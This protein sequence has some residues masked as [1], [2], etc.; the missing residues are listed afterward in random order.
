MEK[1]MSRTLIRPNTRRWKNLKTMTN[2]RHL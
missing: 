1:N 2:H